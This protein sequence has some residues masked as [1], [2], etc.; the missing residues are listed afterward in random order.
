MTDMER[1]R[2]VNS[3]DDCQKAF[4]ELED[5]RRSLQETYTISPFLF[6]GHGNADWKLKTTLERRTENRIYMDEYYN[7]IKR[8]KPEIESFTCKSWEVEYK[9]PGDTFMIAKLPGI[10]Y[11]IY[12]RHHGFPSPLLD[13]TRSFYIAAFFA[14]NNIPDCSQKVTI[15]AFL[16]YNPGKTHARQDPIVSTCNSNVKTDKRH[17]LQQCE[18]T[19]CTQRD[20]GRHYFD[21]HEKV[22][23]NENHLE[24]HLCKVIV[25]STERLKVL[26]HLDCMNINA[27]SLFGSEESLM[28]TM[29]LREYHLKTR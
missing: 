20:G 19:I 25:P 21:C 12:L 3:W 28:E 2:E 27:S 22:L 10:D 1:E 4:K 11:V 5:Y 8:I 7:T 29:A 14:F 17:F 15:Y 23:S 24:N 9:E 18:Y 26:S 6:R 16:E 13:W